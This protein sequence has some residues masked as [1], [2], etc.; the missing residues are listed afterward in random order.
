MLG[1]VDGYWQGVRDVCR[2]QTSDGELAAEAATDK[3]R[4]Y[5]K[6]RSS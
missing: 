3:D 2:S 6:D 4:S 1:S 5:Q